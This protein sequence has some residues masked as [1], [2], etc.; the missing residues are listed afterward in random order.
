MLNT[1]LQSP[2]I[3]SQMHFITANKANLNILPEYLYIYDPLPQNN[4]SYIGQDTSK[5]MEHG[6]P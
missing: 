2:I 3:I 6:R 4:I 1:P 5:H